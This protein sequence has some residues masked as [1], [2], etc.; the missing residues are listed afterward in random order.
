MMQIEGYFNFLSTA[1]RSM[2]FSIPLPNLMFFRVSVQPRRRG[3]TVMH[4]E[5]TKR[6]QSSPEDGNPAPGEEHGAG[7]LSFLHEPTG[8][9]AG[10]PADPGLPAT[11]LGLAVGAQG[12]RWRPRQGF[13]PSAR[14]A[15]LMPS[16]YAACRRDQARTRGWTGSSWCYLGWTLGCGA[17]RSRLRNH[18]KRRT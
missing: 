15:T 6:L 7:Q 18:G 17:L 11:S 3:S 14:L 8:S 10:A 1:D 2:F 13:A 9:T 5:I 12:R 16:R 4:N